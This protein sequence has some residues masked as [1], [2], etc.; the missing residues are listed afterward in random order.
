MEKDKF[1][2]NKRQKKYIKQ[3]NHDQRRDR[4]LLK[5][6]ARN[7]ANKFELQKKGA[8]QYKTMVQQ[9]IKDLLSKQAEISM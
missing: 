2:K 5:K 1:L 4:V 3:W 6:K 9:R 7:T 8:K